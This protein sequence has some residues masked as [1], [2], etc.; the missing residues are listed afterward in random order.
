MFTGLITHTTRLHHRETQNGHTRLHLEPLEITPPPQIGESIA[1]DG[2]CLTLVACEPHWQFDL[3]EE[4]LRCTRFAHIAKG[5]L[6]NIER[7]L[8]VGDFLGGHFLTGH[9]DRAAKVLTWEPS[10][11]VGSDPSRV[12]YHLE[13]E[14]LPHEQPLL[15]EKGS[16]AINGIS[17]T[18]A[19]VHTHSISIY[20][21]PHTRHTT[22]LR[23]Y[24]AGQYVNVEFDLLAKLV[25][26]NL[27]SHLNLS[28]LP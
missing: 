25:R 1:V 13:I 26:K 28:P 15:V 5:A 24:T 6:V 17:L 4:T 7:P 9:I 14:I 20:I 10:P 16:I 23:E 11:Q 2:C 19:S 3:L 8:R 22:N 18:I 27:N 21:I 12:N